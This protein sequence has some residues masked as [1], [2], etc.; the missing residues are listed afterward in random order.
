MNFFRTARPADRS[1]LRHLE[2]R[3][4]PFSAGGRLVERGLEL[5]ELL[6]GFRQRRLLLVEDVLAGLRIDAGQRIDLSGVL[7]APAPRS[8]G[9]APRAAQ[10]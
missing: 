8:R 5:L 10:G 9:T 6:L 1:L 4:S 2:L 3:R 7:A